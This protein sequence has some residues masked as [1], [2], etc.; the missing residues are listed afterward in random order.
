MIKTEFLL[1]A[2]FS[3]HVTMKFTLTYLLHFGLC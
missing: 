3:K 2:L 1:L